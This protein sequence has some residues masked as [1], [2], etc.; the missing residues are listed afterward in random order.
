VGHAVAVDPG[1]VRRDVAHDRAVEDRAG[2]VPKAERRRVVDVV[3]AAVGLVRV[4]HPGPARIGVDPV[5][6]AA[7]LEEVRREADD[8]AVHAA[9]GPT[10]GAPAVDGRV[11]DAG[12]G[13][14]GVDPVVD[15]RG[16]DPGVEAV[17]VAVRAAEGAAVDTV[18]G[19]RRV[20]RRQLQVTLAGGVYAHL[21]GVHLRRPVPLIVGRHPV[22]HLVQRPVALV[23]VRQAVADEVAV[24]GRDLAGGHGGGVLTRRHDRDG[25]GEVL[26]GRREERLTGLVRQVAVVGRARPDVALRV[27]L[28][29]AVG[30]RRRAGGAAEVVLEAHPPVGPRDRHRRGGEGVARHGVAGHHVVRPVRVLRVVRVGSVGRH[31]VRVGVGDIRVRAVGVLRGGVRRGEGVLGRGRGGVVRLGGVGD[32]GHQ[33]EGVDNAVR[34]PA[35]A[36]RDTEQQEDAETRR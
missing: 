35:A 16:E 24:Q 26:A 36:R 23:Q 34:G 32:V 19:H 10:V 6:D 20:G 14:I 13:G 3:A 21:R 27:E 31:A 17:E 25:G 22:H 29:E 7:R 30:V 18:V 2:Q 1:L 8:L 12:P 33:D 28:V 11:V 9:E 4:V 5:R 15:P